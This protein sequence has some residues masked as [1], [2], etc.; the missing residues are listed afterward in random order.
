MSDGTWKSAFLM[1]VTEGGF[2]LDLL[3][4]GGDRPSIVDNLPSNVAP[5]GQ[6]FQWQQ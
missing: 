6:G 4:E 2:K 1:G 5:L 3:L